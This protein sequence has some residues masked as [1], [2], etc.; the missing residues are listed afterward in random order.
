MENN[1]NTPIFQFDTAEEAS[2]YIKVI[3][4]GGGGGNAVNHMFRQGI[5]GVD[6]MICNTDAKAL[7][8]SPVPHKIGL[9]KG[10]GAGNRPEVAKKYAEEK[11]DEIRQAI[12][13]DTKML[14]ITAG[15]GGGT[16]TGAAPV[17]AQIAKSIDLDD[18][19]I[20]KILVV[21]IVTTPFT[22]EGARRMRQAQAG[23]E[24]LSKYVDSML[25]ISNDKL[26]AFGDMGLH[27]CYAKA[28]DVLLIAARGIAEIITVDAYVNIDFQDVNTVM[29]NSG[30]ALMGAGSGRGENRALDAIKAAS[31]SVLLDD[32]DIHGAKNVLLYISF[33]PEHEITMDELT[34]ITDYMNSLTGEDTDMIWGEGPNESLD[35]EINITLIATGFEKRTPNVIV[36][37]DE[38]EVKKLP[39]P[40]KPA[41]DEPYI[42]SETVAE[43]AETVLPTD[44]TPAPAPKEEK[45]ATTGHRYNLY[46]NE[47]VPTTT[48]VAQPKAE[49]TDDIHLVQRE[50]EAPAAVSTTIET[51]KVAAPAPKPIQ[52][53][54][55][56]QGS[57]DQDDL[58]AR[59]RAERIA[60]MHTLLRENPNGAQ[61]A[62][63]MRPDEDFDLDISYGHHSS[64]SASSKAVVSPNGQVLSLNKHLYDNL[65]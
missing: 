11:A 64:A 10:L 4:V 6:F 9:G 15:M 58:R 17:I 30:T 43:K 52:Q 63:S 20:K 36:V 27:G 50:A 65:D 57:P 46:D 8:A 35:D 48:N 54:T 28:D 13:T 1:I 47:S 2:S 32:N 24:E 5:K 25:I 40:A 12:A 34:T 29:E 31:S 45:P 56:L 60:K 19:Y 33:S 21:A 53:P 41:N 39:E 37:N 26:R 18:D 3:G 51:V 16:G 55:T 7:N 22:F 61:I 42:I 38:P 14:F 44:S 59:A 49:P 62:G 23:I